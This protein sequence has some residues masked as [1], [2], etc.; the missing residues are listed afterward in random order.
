M[1]SHKEIS[2][3]IPGDVEYCPKCQ[4]KMILLEFLPA[5]REKWYCMTCKEFLKLDQLDLEKIRVDFEIPVFYFSN[6]RFPYMDIK[7]KLESE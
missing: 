7:D 6:D 2:A 4:A 3:I 1:N 5:Y